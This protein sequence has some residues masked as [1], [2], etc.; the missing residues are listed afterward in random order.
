VLRLQGTQSSDSAAHDDPESLGVHV[1]D[2][3][4][5]PGLLRRLLSRPDG[6]L[7]K[8]IGPANLLPV[9]VHLGIESLHFAREP[10]GMPGSV[11]ACDGSRA[12]DPGYKRVPGF[13]D[14]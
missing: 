7:K 4:R 13:G 3:L 14:I 1:R 9:H 2:A 6:E 10:D 11:E 5:Q 8:P 12:R